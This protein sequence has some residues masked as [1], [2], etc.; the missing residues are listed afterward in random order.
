MKNSDEWNE[1]KKEIDKQEKYLKFNKRD[2]FFMYVGE[3]VGYEQN[4][5]GKEFLRPVLV[6]KRFSDRYFLGI[7]LSSKEKN[8]TYFFSFTHKN[9]LQTALLNQIRV[10]DIKRAKYFFGKIGFDS[11]VKL[12]NQFLN[13][14]KVTPQKEGSNPLGQNNI[15]IIPQNDIKI[16]KYNQNYEKIWDEFVKTSKNGNIF[17]TRKFLSYHPKDRFEDKSILIY[18]KNKLIAIFPAIEFENKIISH[19]G[20]TYGGLVVGVKNRLNDSL[21]IWQKIIEYYDKTIEFR[22]CEYIFDNYPSREVEFS[23]KKLGFYEVNE[24]LSTCLDLDFIKLSDRRKRA[25]KKCD[26]LKI[27]FD[28]ID[29]K[30]YHKILTKNL[31]KYNTNPTHSLEEMKTLK[32]LLPNNYFLVTIYKDNQMIAGIWLVLATNKTAHTFYIAQNYYFSEFQPLSCIVKK[33]IEY[34]K[35]KNYKYLNFG[36]STENGGKYLN[37]GLFEFKES[38]GGFGVSRFYFRRDV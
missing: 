19:R 27:V 29:Y 37:K 17:H 6:Y 31:T 18:K 26:N 13:L 11:F 14:F 7:P 34:L 10:F 32:K 23:A 25:I 1:I 33:I 9:K 15:R 30:E 5:K 12:E 16:V 24:E 8:G 2:I 3:N 4:G 22:K 21:E 28:D 35:K 38:F 36:I 20:S